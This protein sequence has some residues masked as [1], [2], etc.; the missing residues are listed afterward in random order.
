MK[1]LLS[2]LPDSPWWGCGVPS[3][4][5]NPAM[6]LGVKPNQ[7]KLI[8]ERS[9]LISI[10]KNIDIKVL[11]I[12]FPDEFD[13]EPKKHDFV[14]IRD[15]FISDQNG[16]A[17]ILKM[18]QPNRISESL[19]VASLLENLGLNIIHLPDKPNMYAEGGEFYYC[20]KENILFSGISR[21]SILGAETVSELLNVDELVILDSSSFHLDTFFTPVLNP[22]GLICALIVCME[23]L[24]S[25]SVKDLNHFANK[26]GIPIINVPIQDSIGTKNSPGSFSANALPLP[27]VLIG[28]N[29]FT[30]RDI[31][32][33]LE[34]MDVMRIVTSTTQFELSGG[35]IH[36][37]TNEI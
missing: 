7:K 2:K 33:Q 23:I 4:D 12:P 29:H 14:F 11:E 9:Q 5:D 16:N 24:S 27:G 6:Q 22:N 17:I 13:S 19:V 3:Y 31:D 1:I 37:I 30:N 36:C 21:N 32:I 15:P 28:P 8:K 10:L 26:K 18:R 34:K 20:A 35:S 25:N